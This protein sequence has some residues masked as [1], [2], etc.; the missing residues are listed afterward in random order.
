MADGKAASTTKEAAPQRRV[1]YKLDPGS[2]VTSPPRELLDAYLNNNLKGHAEKDKE[3][4]DGRYGA[5]ADDKDGRAAKSDL[6]SRGLQNELDY[7]TGAGTG[8]DAEGMNGYRGD[9]KRAGVSDAKKERAQARETTA[10]KEEEEEEEEED[11][12][13]PLALDR[14]ASI[15]ASVFAS[16]YEVLE[17]ACQFNC[18][19]SP[20]GEAFGASPGAAASSIHPEAVTAHLQRVGFQVVATGPVLPPGDMSRDSGSTGP[21]DG[22][23][24]FKMFVFA[25]GYKLKQKEGVEGDAL[26][27]FGLC[28]LVIKREKD[29]EA[30]RW[31]MSLAVRCTQK[32]HA[33]GF[34]AELSLGNLFELK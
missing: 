6:D 1:R 20:V 9:A 26:P 14:G 5:A 4:D 30:D 13:T 22:I 2:I 16:L 7:L 29:E 15:E 31:G 8:P 10:A 12:D 25:S 32:R 33:T 3:A 17:P 28:E 19:I 27:I 23:P 34:V 11:E 18:E 21:P 24:G